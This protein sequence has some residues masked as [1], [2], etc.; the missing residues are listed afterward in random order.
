MLGELRKY[1]SELRPKLIPG[2]KGLRYSEY[3]FSHKTVFVSVF[4][5][6]GFHSQYGPLWRWAICFSPICSCGSM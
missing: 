2:L 4:Q 6:K 3:S 1:R 5:K